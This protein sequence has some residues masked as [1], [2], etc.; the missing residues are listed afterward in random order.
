MEKTMKQ[1]IWES[2][3]FPIILIG[4][5]I[6]GCV[7]GMVMG[8]RAVVLKPLGEIFL[9]LMFTIVVPLVFLTISSAVGSMV[10]MKRLGKILGTLLGAFLVTGFIAGILSIVIVK[11]IPPALGANISITAADGTAE[12][13]KISEQIVGMLTVNDF[14]GLF[15]KSNMVPLIVFSILFG[16]AVSAI[17]GEDNIVSKGL[18]ALTQVI[19]KLVDYI[20]MY[21]PIGL[22][23][24]FAALIGEFGPQ[25]LGSYGR[26]ISIYY[27]T[28]GLLSD[29]LYPVCLLCGRPDRCEGHVQKYPASRCDLSS[30]AE[31][32]R[33]PAC[34]PG[35]R[36]QD[37]Y[38]QGYSR[39]RPADWRHC[40]SGRHRDLRC[41]EDRFPVRP[42]WP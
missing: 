40:T 5:I 33:H 31:F 13:L 3:R 14:S 18:N 26:L 38:P 39:H 10:N 7:I 12:S 35:C 41:H 42:V 19:L 20:M 28:C 2:Y 37:R 1:K 34:Q 30:H 4:A 23:T 6:L 27:P 11:L 24:Y 25:L 16:L 36:R 22:G 21:A 8:E 9:N 15:S 17:G 29:F 32:H